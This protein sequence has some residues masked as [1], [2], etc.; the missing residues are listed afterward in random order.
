[1]TDNQIH[2][3][4]QHRCQV[5]RERILLILNPVVLLITEYEILIAK[6]QQRGSVGCIIYGTFGLQ[7][8]FAIK[9]VIAHRID[10][11]HHRA[12]YLLTFGKSHVRPAIII[13]VLGNCLTQRF[14]DTFVCPFYLIG[15]DGHRALQLLRL[16]AKCRYTEKADYNFSHVIQY[17]QYFRFVG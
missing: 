15:V 2:I 17:S 16:C 7:L 5:R 12:L 11:K 4:C 1:M 3:I 6:V 14:E 8:H 10:N 9:Q 13:H